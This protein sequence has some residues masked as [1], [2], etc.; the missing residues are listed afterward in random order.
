[1]LPLESSPADVRQAAERVTQLAAEYLRTINERSTFPATTG[2]QSQELFHGPLPEKGIG[3]DA[4]N[5]LQDVINCSR[6]QNGRFFGYVLGSGEPIAATADLLTSVLNQN[7]TAWRSGPAAVTIERTVVEWLAEAM[8]C[9]G[10]SGRL[11]GGGSSRNLMARAM[12]REAKA[13]ANDGGLCATRQ[14]VMYASSEIHM[15]IPKSIALLGIGRDNLRLIP[16]DADYRLVPSALEQAIAEDVKAG[17]LPIAVVASAGTVNTGSIDPFNE[18]AAI[19]RRHHLWF[20]ID[21]AYGDR[22]SKCL[23]LQ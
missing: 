8:G 22:K 23:N 2:V 6:V 5:Q 14:P 12:A 4:L 10:F 7:V 13:A 16:V 3:L 11:T 9:A 20:H 19:A 17:K 21:G 18:I 15:S 1:M